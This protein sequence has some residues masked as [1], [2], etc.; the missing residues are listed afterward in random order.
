MR[1]YTISVLGLALILIFV[2][3]SS[4]ENEDDIGGKATTGDLPPMITIFDK[5]YVAPYMPV[6]ELP[7][8]YEYIGDLP[9]EFANDT[10]L[11]G[12]KMYAIK[13]FNTLRQWAYVRWICSGMPDTA[14]TVVFRR[15]NTVERFIC[16]DL[17]E[18]A[19][20]SVH[21]SYCKGL[22]KILVIREP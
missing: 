17:L 8:G 19:E 14:K 1:K 13:E 16:L 15:Q 18:T 5:N 3:R 2:S 10:G 11:A 6:D 9:E 22:T 21:C 20:T 4:H 12:C 7:D